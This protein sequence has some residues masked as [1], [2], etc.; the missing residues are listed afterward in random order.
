V[1]PEPDGRPIGASNFNHRTKEGFHYEQWGGA[2]G[3]LDNILPEVSMYK[4]TW[5]LTSGPYHQSE[6]QLEEHRNQ[7]RQILAK[8]SIA[9]NQGLNSFNLSWTRY[10]Y[11]AKQLNGTWPALEDKSFIRNFGDE[12]IAIK[13]PGYY[14]AIYVGKPIAGS[15]YRKED[16]RLWNVSLPYDISDALASPEVVKDLGNRYALPMTGG[17]MSLFWT[18]DFGNS[19]LAQNWSPLTHHGLLACDTEGKGYYEDY[20]S[21]THELNEQKGTLTVSGRIGNKPVAYERKYTFRDYEV[22]IDLKLQVKK[23][24]VFARF[25]EIVPIAIGGKSYKSNN[26]KMKLSGPKSSPSLFD[27]V[28]ITDRNQKGVLLKTLEPREIKL[29]KGIASHRNEEIL[30]IAR[31]EIPFPEKLKKGDVLRL[32]YSLSPLQ[33]KPQ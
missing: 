26:P 15:S 9:P 5:Y 18:R 27:S 2:T 7:I 33:Y 23:D 19:L 28:L 17:G 13:R 31:I 11:W 3:I 8:Y 29:S 1:A 25:L 21:I 14:T 10:K 30:Q 20:F 12:L 32:S 4:P 6:K 16:S 22:K 24:C